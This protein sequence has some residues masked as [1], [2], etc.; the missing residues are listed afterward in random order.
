MSPE[1]KPHNGLQPRGV[2]HVLPSERDA[3]RLGNLG[4]ALVLQGAGQ[5][6]QLQPDV[7]AIGARSLGPA[8]KFREEHD[9]GHLLQHHRRYV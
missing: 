5:K 6:R 8:G 4:R 9:H 7:R 3:V 1:F 2:L